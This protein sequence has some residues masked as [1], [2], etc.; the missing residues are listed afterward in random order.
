MNVVKTPHNDKKQSVRR[1]G[2]RKGPS[3][4]PIN[5][6]EW[7][8]ACQ[9]Y[10][11]LEV[12]MKQAEF[13][14][15]DLSSS[16]FTK[17]TRSQQQSFGRMLKKYDDG[18]LKP[19]EGKRDKIRKYITIEKKMIDFI[20]LETLNQKTENPSLSW[21]LLT[22]KCK[23]W[24]ENFPEF[25]ASPGWIHKTMQRHGIYK[26]H[27][28]KEDQHHHHQSQIK[29]SKKITTNTITK[30]STLPQSILP[31]DNPDAFFH[32][33]D[34]SFPSNF[35]HG[36]TMT[37]FITHIDRNPEMV[38]RLSSPCYEVTE[39]DQYVYLTMY[40]PGFKIED[41]ETS[42]SKNGQVLKVTGKRK[43]NECETKFQKYFNIGYGIDTNK[44][45]AKLEK[46]ILVLQGPKKQ[47][48][49]DVQKILKIEEV[50]YVT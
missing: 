47:K 36:A 2:R 44:I 17:C 16:K 10:R 35:L 21:A 46:D 39:D 7:Y 48:S 31:I 20:R 24:A 37:P 3:V 28:F 18:V 43:L 9:T 1:K 8:N 11:G 19:H 23:E 42:I 26:G 15:S 32:G 38:L 12:K 50:N 4:L 40:I 27:L 29:E 45:I 14:R 30:E 41:I 33:F 25:K 6:A 34:E 22:K 49:D 5:I 13:L